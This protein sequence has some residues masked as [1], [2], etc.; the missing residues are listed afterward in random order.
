MRVLFD[1]QERWH[2]GRAL[3]S[4]TIYWHDY[5]TFGVNPRQDRASQFA[6]IRTDE[7]LNEVGEP[8]MFYCKPANDMLPS[9]YACL[10]TG[11]SPYK[12]LSEGV[13][14]AEFIRRIHQEFSKPQT[15]V[16]GYNSLRFDDEVTRQLLYRNF[17]DPY[18]REWKNGNSRWDIIDMVRLCYALRPEGIVWPKK[19]DGSPSFRLEELTAANGISHADAHDALSDV[20]AT[21]AMARLIKQKQPKLYD[22][23]Y[24][25]RSKHE[26]NALIDVVTKQPVVHVSAMYPASVGCLALVAPL[27]AHPTDKNGFIVYDLRMDPRQ[28]MDLSVEDIQRRL[29]TRT[30]D[31][32]EGEER[33]P[34]KVV[35]SNRCPVVASA[36]LLSEDLAA[37]YAIDL[38]QSQEHLQI[39]L[40]NPSLISKVASAFDTV[41]ENKPLAEQ[42]PDFMIYSGGFF[43][44]GD[45]QAMA[46]IR[47]STPAELADWNGAFRDRRLSTM[48][49]RYRARNFGDS[50]NADERQ[51]WEQYRAAQLN[52]SAEAQG[53]GVCPEQ[54]DKDL[55]EIVAGDISAEQQVLVDELRR[56]KEEIRISA[57]QQS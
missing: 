11:I 37:K 45:K 19:D 36:K 43:G 54:F 31:L 7:D 16:S 34:L 46:Q 13:S 28:W 53:A 3:L 8:L 30:V 39:L 21:I 24:K 57:A 12:A 52:R 23:V 2:S 44:A 4:N 10:I 14:E 48:L 25:L 40:D 6:G 47:G 29:F 20:R 32:G 50:L 42:D 56:Y 41:Y 49:L 5:E 27:T 22:Y 1:G 55:A 9:P 35:H 26:V 17:Y 38:K 18:E 15:C 51:Q 33:I